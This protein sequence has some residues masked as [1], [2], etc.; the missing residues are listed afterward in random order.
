MPQ[1]WLRVAHLRPLGHRLRHLGWQAAVVLAMA[2]LALTPPGSAWHQPEE[3]TLSAD[4]DA[5]MAYLA[6]TH[7]VPRYL[8]EAAHATGR[9]PAVWPEEQPILERLA[10][11]EHDENTERG[12][13]R[14]LGMAHGLGTSG[15]DPRTTTDTDLVAIINGRFDGVQ[16]GDP[17]LLNDDWWAILALQAAGLP[18]DAPAIQS[19]ATY[20]LGHQQPDGSWSHQI[21]LPD[22]LP[23]NTAAALIALHGANRLT[24][25]RAARGLAYIETY[26]HASSGYGGDRPNCQSTVW[27]LQARAALDQAW[28]PGAASFL[29]GLQRDDGGFATSPGFRSDP[30]CTAE[31][32]PLLA[33][34]YR[35]WAHYR[36][37][38]LLLPPEVPVA[39]PFEAAVDGGFDHL[40]W[41]LGS[42]FREGSAGHLVALEPG[43]HTLAL[44]ARGTGGVWRGEHSILVTNQAPYLS[45]SHHEIV[46][47]RVTRM[48]WSAPIQD[49]EGQMLTYDWS[50]HPTNAVIEGGRLSAIFDTLGTFELVVT[51]TDPHGASTQATL[52][53][54]VDNVP[55][56]GMLPWAEPDEARPSGNGTWH[57]TL[58]TAADDAD[59]PKPS[60]SWELANQTGRGVSAEFHLTTGHHPGHVII[61]DADG[62]VATL[63]FHVTVA[64]TGTIGVAGGPPVSPEVAAV[65][66]EASNQAA[67]GSN[68]TAQNLAG[69]DHVSPW[70]WLDPPAGG[71]VGY[72]LLFQADPHPTATNFQFQWGDGGSSGRPSA[73]LTHPSSSHAWG[74]A[75][76]YTVR[77]LAWEPGFPTEVLHYRITIDDPSGKQ[78]WTPTHQGSNASKDAPTL[79]A[80][81]PLLMGW[82]VLASLVRRFARHP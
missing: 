75:G 41:D 78:D 27:A 39:T 13:Y 72:P 5:A 70:Q 53:V 73:P 76:T 77:L 69:T 62:A 38:E 7:F 28:P 61:R 1:S 58:Q 56:T 20:I 80:G 79:V 29:E 40:Q 25:D 6:D 74:A 57:V 82:L 23:D 42:A 30:W 31:A 3:E 8:L 66:A 37:G 52:R 9:N 67:G 14:L 48:T 45:P 63:P 68:G 34:H 47:D 35:P 24:D 2:L 55:P 65:D 71:T 49:P 59:G 10:P 21:G 32:V 36:D 11:D 4:L 50:G 19:A 51:A 60:V 81:G 54:N 17:T 33:G 44:V 46:V 43:Q 64:D 22:F 16:F 18:A 15:Y 12:Y 26:R